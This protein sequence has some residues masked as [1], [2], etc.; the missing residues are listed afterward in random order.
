MRTLLLF[1][2]LGSLFISEV[3]Y[4]RQLERYAIENKRGEEIVFFINHVAAGKEAKDLA[5]WVQGS[6]AQSVLGKQGM[7]ENALPQHDIVYAEKFKVDNPSEFYKHDCRLRRVADLSLVLKH[8]LQQRKR[9]DVFLIGTSEGGVIAPAVAIKHKEVTRVLIL[10]SGGMNQAGELSILARQGLLASA[11]ISSV[12]QLK[13]V[14][15]EIASNP[16]VNN[17][18]FGHT[19]K[20]WH[21]YLWYSPARDIARLHCPILVIMGSADQSAPVESALSLRSLA[22]IRD[23]LKVYIASGLDHSFRDKAGKL[24]LPALAAKVIIPWVENT[25]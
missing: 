25:Q 9:R 5:I 4:A 11:G 10:G 3:S 18:W 24:Q 23:N 1:F 21:S 12:P 15:K 19:Y 16:S 22:Q 2:I 8:L 7:T 17:R 20:R 6:S 13:K 14:F